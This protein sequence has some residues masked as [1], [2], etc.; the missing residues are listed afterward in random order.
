MPVRR[1]DFRANTRLL[2]DANRQLV[3]LNFFLHNTIRADDN[4]VTVDE[5][6]RR[7]LLDPHSKHFDQLAVFALH[8]S[9][10][11]VRRGVAGVSGQAGFLNKY[12]RTQVWL[13]GAWSRSALSEEAIETWF[14]ANL[15]VSGQDTA[16]K[17]TTNYRF[18]LSLAGYLSGALDVVNT[19]AD[20][21]ATAA[22]WLAF[23]RWQQDSPRSSWGKED[24]A[25]RCVSDELY[26]LM[27]LPEERFEYISS[28]AAADYL[29]AGGLKRPLR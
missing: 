17:C 26:K 18:I 28:S 22:F 10:L 23:D 19:R 16:H 7:A 9:V 25:R 21:W 5:L 14:D 15:E 8:L 1:D 6:V 29:R 13:D 4:F 11:G 27:G 3:P 12:V 20:E 24:L 2:L